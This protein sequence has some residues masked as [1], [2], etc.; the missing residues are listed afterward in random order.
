MLHLLSV[1]KKIIW[2]IFIALFT[3]GPLPGQITSTTADHV[4]TIAYPVHTSEDPLFIFYQTYQVHKPGTLTATLPGNDSFNFQWSCIVP[5]D[6]GEKLR[7]PSPARRVAVV[8]PVPAPG[9]SSP[10]GKTGHRK[11]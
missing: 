1:D 8:Y 2:G 4:D 11:H 6:R 9:W 3:L 5:R 7:L 10:S